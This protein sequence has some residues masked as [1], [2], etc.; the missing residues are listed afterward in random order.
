MTTKSSASVIGYHNGFFA[1]MLAGR[2]RGLGAQLFPGIVPMFALS[3]LLILATL[4]LPL[5]GCFL[6][7]HKI[8]VQQ[9]NYVDQ[10]ML[11]KLKTG[12]TKSQ[13]RYVLGTP[14]VTDPFHPE[15]WDYAYMDRPKGK[16]KSSRR[17]TVIFEGERLR[18]LEGDVPPLTDGAGGKSALPENNS[19]TGG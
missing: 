13:V 12:M 7:P 19:R 4:S 16:L 1:Q 17:V 18:R 14:L 2:M 3:R 9:G 11:A 10:A 15:R 6:V 8:D 5:G